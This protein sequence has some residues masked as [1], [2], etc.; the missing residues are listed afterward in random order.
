[1]VLHSTPCCVNIR[2]YPQKSFCTVFSAKTKTL[3]ACI[4]GTKLGTLTTYTVEHHMHIQTE[5][6]YLLKMRE[7]KNVHTR[8]KKV[9]N[10]TKLH[11]V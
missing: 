5:E 2:F 4:L 9:P 10:W 6:N 3:V 8:S 11:A 1:M 7:S